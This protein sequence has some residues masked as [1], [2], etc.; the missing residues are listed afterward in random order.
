VAFKVKIYEGSK[1]AGEEDV[2][3]DDWFVLATGRY[4]V[5][6]EQHFSNGTVNLTL[7]KDTDHGK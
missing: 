2:G 5:A 7:K 3:D 1:L 4:Y 6:N